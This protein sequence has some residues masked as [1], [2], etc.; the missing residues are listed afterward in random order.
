MAADRSGYLS[1]AREAILRAATLAQRP[2][3]AY[4]AAEWR[5]LIEHEAGHHQAE[6]EPVREL[7]EYAPR[8][9]RTLAA[10]RRARGC[11]GRVR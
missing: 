5:A 6:L 9:P 7:V 8:D 11:T 10:L 4:Q 2:D 1:R 3:E